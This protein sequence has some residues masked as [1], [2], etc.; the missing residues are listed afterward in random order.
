MSHANAAD[1]IVV[2]SGAAGG[3]A[4]K[5][6]TE[7]GLRVLLLEAGPERTP[8]GAGRAWAVRLWRHARGAQ[9]V[10]E[11]Q[12]KYWVEDPNLFVTD[13][14]QPYSTPPERP[15]SWIRSRQLGGRTLLW[16]GVALR[17]SD[18][19]LAAAEHDGCGP[20]WPLRYRDLAPYYDRVERFLGIHGT[21]EGLPQ[22][23]DG[24]F[25]GERPLTRAERRLGDRVAAAWP[26]RRL[27][28]SRGL[29]QAGH[30]NGE[31]RLTSVATSIRAAQ[32]TGRL[33]VRT[34]AAVSHLL[35]GGPAGGAGGVLYLEAATGAARAARAR[36][37]VLCASTIETIRILLTTKQEHPELPVDESECLGRYLMDHVM[38]GMTLEME[39]VPYDPPAP[40]TGA[41]QFLVPRFQNLGR[42]GAEPYLRGFGLWGAIQRRGFAGRRRALG[43]MVAQ[44]EMLPRRDNRVELDGNRGGD[45]LRGVRINC[46]WGDNERAMHHAMGAAIE[47]M[48]RA[49]GGRTARRFGALTGLPGLPGLPARL[50][51]YW[52]APPPGA[53]VHEVGG[54]R[55]GSD[56]D[57]SVV[58]ARNRCWR[59]PNVLVTDGACWPTSGWQAPTLTMMALTA[60]ACSLAAADL[61][62]GEL[63]SGPSMRSRPLRAASGRPGARKVKTHPFD[64]R[65]PPL[66]HGTDFVDA[67]RSVWC[68]VYRWR[69]A[70]RFTVVPSL[71]GRPVY[72]Y[73]PG[74]DY[75]D[76][77]AAA[78]ADL[79]R[80]IPNRR[81]N[82]RVLSAPRPEGELAPDAPVTMRI[83]LAV[84]GRSPEAVWER[85]LNRAARKA[86][87]RARKA[88]L[89]VAE[90]T[91]PGAMQ[92]IYAMF[93]LAN[94]R[95]GAPLPPSAL[96]EALVAEMGG[97]IIVVRGRA[98]GEVRAGLLWVR[99]GPIALV[100]Y[101]GAYHS[102]DCPGNLLFWAAVEQAA[103]D[104]A[105][106][107]DFGRSPAGSG[108]YRFKRN[109]GASPIPILWLSDKAVD[110]YRRYR[111]AQNLW[112]ALP[113]AITDRAGPRLCRYLADY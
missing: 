41:D 111:V 83:D 104:G 27:I 57:A 36:L 12:P 50:E 44:G 19:E 68:G 45:G 8:A 26:D 97:R 33:Q 70:G 46:G 21:C 94:A 88:G 81:F 55:M 71:V 54:A 66:R 107:L 62:R 86:V 18:Y 22:L 10:Q 34:G 109:F 5:E 72:A 93:R 74:L 89:A 98:S 84:F 75:S 11:W 2:G 90:E 32:A 40:F 37:I 49:G 48:V 108:T 106:I 47:E 30:G 52:F 9:R 73:L 53:A 87:R 92:A 7:A 42:P 69:Q 43:L 23:P 6:L 59:M 61:R 56:P 14:E 96:F 13:V 67:W 82:I 78:A 39:G 63:R 3:W 79:A 105:D 17:L 102:A 15:F 58:D 113:D 95:H 20:S 16:G 65:R 103:H 4:A 77:D 29:A 64:D 100:P 25:A 1:A 28:P 35:P 101:S 51:R 91:G 85:G 80:E 60:R 24:Q 99:S 110:P 31:E 76:L 112:R 38:L